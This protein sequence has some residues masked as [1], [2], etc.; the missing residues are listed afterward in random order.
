MREQINYRKAL[1]TGAS[2]GIGRGL[3]LALG[4][5]GT[6]VYAAARRKPELDSLVAEIARA[7]GRAEALVL[8]VSDPEEAHDVVRALD[9][10]D[11]LDLVVANAGVGGKTPSTRPAY[12]DV[13]HIFDVN[14]S[15]AI[16]TLYGALPGMVDR[17]HGHLVGVASLAGMRGLPKYSAYSASKAALITFLESTRLDLLK[18]GVAVTAVCPGYVRT[19]MTAKSGER[20]F[21][22]DVDQAVKTIL[23]SL[24]RKDAVCAFPRPTA[25][26]MRSAALLP[27]SVYEFVFTRSKM[28]R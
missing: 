28:S 4:R 14:L 21:M 6:F 17:N 8:D 2:S 1:V 25:T 7:G 12:H 11:P 26:V 15:G 22:I 19:E 3:A 13:Q 9:A 24:A 20:P 16:A 18:T 23:H 27:S 5:A 10:R